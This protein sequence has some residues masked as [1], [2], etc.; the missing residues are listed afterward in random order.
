[1]T[2]GC[3]HSSVP[4]V[5]SAARS[6]YFAVKDLDAFQKA[7]N[8]FGLFQLQKD[9]Q[10]RVCVLHVEPD[11]RWGHWPTWVEDEDGELE[12]FDFFGLI[13]SHLKD[14]EVA[15]FTHVSNDKLRSIVGYA[16]AVNS[17]GDV[18]QVSLSD[19]WDKA[20]KMG[21]SIDKSSPPMMA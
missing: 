4:A 7:M 15:V 10:D 14:G 9:S 18:Q 19:I 20:D 6:N 12:P 8:E 11:Y 13:A 2:I 16:V 3:N 21:S 5:S 1:M 17:A